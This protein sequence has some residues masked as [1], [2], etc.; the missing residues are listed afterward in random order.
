MT[1]NVKQGKTYSRELYYALLKN[2]NK[3]ITK[4]CSVL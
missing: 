3:E 2:A 4:S 1:L